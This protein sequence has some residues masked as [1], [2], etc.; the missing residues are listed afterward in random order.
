PTFESQATPHFPLGSTLK[1]PYDV[2]SPGSSNLAAP[3][4]QKSANDVGS[5]GSS[6]RTNGPGSCSNRC[7]TPGNITAA[8]CCTAPTGAV[9]TPARDSS[10]PMAPVAVQTPQAPST[11]A[12]ALDHYG[13]LIQKPGGYEHSVKRK[14]HLHEEAEYPKSHKTRRMDE[15]RTKRMPLPRVLSTAKCLANK[16]PVAANNAKNKRLVKK[17][18]NLHTQLG[19]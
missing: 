16:Q 4:P 14:Q 12:R 10:A 7:T 8:D 9:T 5:P 15:P 3:A 19:R 17:L 11:S 18:V 13:Q 6:N 2:G 1:S